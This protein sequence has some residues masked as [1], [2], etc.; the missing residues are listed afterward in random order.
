M[1]RLFHAALRRVEEADPYMRNKY[2]RLAA[3]RRQKEVMGF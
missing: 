2:S 3:R 1:C